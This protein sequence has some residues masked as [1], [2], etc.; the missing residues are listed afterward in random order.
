MIN[1]IFF[2]YNYDILHIFINRLIV[3]NR[4]FTGSTKD[5]PQYYQKMYDKGSA[6]IDKYITSKEKLEWQRQNIYVL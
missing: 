4:F 6:F 3:Y 1:Y 5:L 2:Y